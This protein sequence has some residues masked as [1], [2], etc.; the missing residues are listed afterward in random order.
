MWYGAVPVRPPRRQA[1]SVVLAEVV[2]RAEEGAGGITLNAIK[3][4]GGSGRR[5]PAPGLVPDWSAFMLMRAGTG[6]CA[7]PG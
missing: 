4:P 3:P 2:T 5:A 6:S 7:G 1:H